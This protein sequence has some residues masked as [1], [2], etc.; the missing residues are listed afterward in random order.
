MPA[1]RSKENTSEVKLFLLKDEIPTSSAQ[2]SKKDLIA[3]K[4]SILKQF[5]IDN[6]STFI[7]LLQKANTKQDLKTIESTVAIDEFNGGA[8]EDEVVVELLHR[9]NDKKSASR[10]KSRS[11]SKLLPH[12]TDHKQIRQQ[13]DSN[14]LDP[15]FENKCK[16]QKCL[17]GYIT[18][19]D[20]EYIAIINTA[21]QIKYISKTE[22]NTDINSDEGDDEV[23]V[24]VETETEGFR[25]HNQPVSKTKLNKKIK[26]QSTDEDTPPSD[27]KNPF[28]I[29]LKKLKST[30]VPPDITKMSL[31]RLDILGQ[32]V[33]QSKQLANAL[34]IK[35][36]KYGQRLIIIKPIKTL[37]SIPIYAIMTTA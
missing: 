35:S 17:L 9:V 16:N 2:D 29:A 36:P 31:D 23:D 22:D 18:N 20:N 3:E 6:P 19:S 30:F 4:S 21:G 37:S 34:V 5:F 24:E 10:I 8:V 28:K 13:V 27:S 14:Q 1:S 33:N 32:V 26:T 25:S 11:A 7:N 15:L 12:K